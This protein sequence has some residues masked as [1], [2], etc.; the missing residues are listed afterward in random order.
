MRIGRRD[1]LR[2]GAVFGAAA[3]TGCTTQLDGTPVPATTPPPGQPL[4]G[5]VR[6]GVAEYR[7]YAFEDDAGELT[8]EVVEVVRA[9]CEKLGSSLTVRAVPYET[10]LENVESGELDVVGGLSIRSKN[11]ASLDF[12]APDHLSL[13][14]IVVRAGNPK[15]INTFTEVASTRAR[16]GVVA[17]ALEADNAQAAG[18]TGLRTYQSSE[19]LVQAVLEDQVDCAAYDDITLRDLLPAYAGLELRPPFE[20]VGGAPRY[21]FGFRKGDDSGL[22][23]AFDVVLRNLHA[24]GEWLRITKPF[25]FTR[26]NL[27]DAERVGEEACAR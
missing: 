2:A 9:I 14:A 16:L 13:T 12:T 11:C 22:R 19:E 27:P 24:S 5:T 10:I 6:L 3:L 26:S 4:P 1:L 25:G 23:E 17:N 7:P 20:P 21:G 8:G 15:G 18:V